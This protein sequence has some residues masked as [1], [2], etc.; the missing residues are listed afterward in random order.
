MMQVVWLQKTWWVRD[1]TEC[2]VIRQT[3]TSEPS[4]SGGHGSDNHGCS[5]W[6]RGRRSQEWSQIMGAWLWGSGS[7][8]QGH[9]AKGSGSHDA[10]GQT[11]SDSATS[12]SNGNGS[13]AVLSSI[14]C[15]TTGIGG[16]SLCLTH[17]CF[18]LLGLIAS[19]LNF[20]YALG[21]L[22]G[23]TAYIVVRPS[24]LFTVKL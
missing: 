15:T 11:T 3:A 14:C 22:E 4:E 16:I 21:D 7:G 10:T 23:Y 19:N 1:I 6:G 17:F 12:R 8:S 24:M 18:T 2:W 9:G 5:P 13:V 20:Y